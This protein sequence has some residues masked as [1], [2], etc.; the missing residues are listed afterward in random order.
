MGLLVDYLKPGYG[1]TNDGNSARRFF[2][3]H[4]LSSFIT[5]IDIEIINNFKVVLQTISSGYYIN[6]EKFEAYTLKTAKLFVEKYP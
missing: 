5:G 2:E 1:S 3:N 6:I 4:N